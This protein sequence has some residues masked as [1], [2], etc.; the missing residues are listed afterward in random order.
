MAEP[1]C[2]FFGQRFDGQLQRG[3]RSG[4]QATAVRHQTKQIT[5]FP[6]RLQTV[7]ICIVLCVLIVELN[8][9]PEISFRPP[10]F[11]SHWTHWFNPPRS[12]F[13]KQQAQTQNSRVLFYASVISLLH[14]QRQLGIHSSFQEQLSRR[15]HRTSKN[16]QK[17]KKT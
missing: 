3:A 1:L 8:F 10:P 6:N 14:P 12:A 5:G 9:S 7:P 15:N 4:T 11:S 17:T 13:P 16:L 2:E